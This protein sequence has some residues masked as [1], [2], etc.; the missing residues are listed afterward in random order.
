LLLFYTDGITEAVNMQYEEF[1]ELRLQRTLEELL[2][3]NPEADADSLLAAV[4]EA[5]R[6]FTADMIPFDDST[7]FLVRRTG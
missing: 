7:L 1:G 5:V 3:K 4:L 6:L 2:A